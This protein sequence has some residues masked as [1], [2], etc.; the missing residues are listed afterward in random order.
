MKTEEGS[1]EAA[2]AKAVDSNNLGLVS[3]ADQLISNFEKI[4]EE[5]YGFLVDPTQPLWYNVE[6]YIKEM[7][8]IELESRP[9]SMACHN[10]LR[11][12]PLA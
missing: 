12:N 3:R 8:M 1:E 5:Q 6:I 2:E 7:T 11:L 9:S 10:L 4:S